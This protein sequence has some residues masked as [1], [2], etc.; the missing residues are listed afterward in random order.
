M[1]F[2]VEDGTGLATA[3][4]YVSLAD[5]ELYVADF[6]PTDSNWSG[7][8]DAN[9][10]LALMKATQ[11]LDM[12]YGMRWKGQRSQT[13][14]A[15][16]WPKFDVYDSDDL[17]IE[18]DVVPIKI[19]HATLEIALRVLAGDSLLAPVGTGDQRLTEKSVKVGSI[20]VSSKFASP[21][22]SGHKRYDVVQRLVA[23]FINPVGQVWRA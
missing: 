16:D 23:E 19:T 2:V 10:Q 8:S 14:Q 15:L 17:L 1:T 12:V 13:D 6:H 20:A 4:S 22:K 18:H 3:T 5:A 7:A 21:G 11:Y 9:K